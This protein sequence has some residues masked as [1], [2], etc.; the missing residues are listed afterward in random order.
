MFRKITLAAVLALSMIVATIGYISGA[1]SGMPI[2]IYVNERE[3]STDVSPFIENGTTFVPVRSICNAMRIDDIRW[4]GSDNTV[5]IKAENEIQFTVGE[6]YA[7]VNGKKHVL[8]APTVI[9]DGRTMIPVRLLAEAFGAYVEWDKTLY[10]VGISKD[11]LDVPSDCVESE[12]TKG[13]LLWLARIVHAESVGEPFDG[14]LAVANVVLN[15]VASNEY[16]NTIYGVIFDRKYGVQFQPVANGT[17]YNTPSKLSVM[18]S[19]R[20]LMGENNIGNCLYFL[21]ESIA[22][23]SWI[24][25]NREYYAKIHNHSFYV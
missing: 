13:D 25:E 24:T 8:S 3:I 16:P 12:Y 5:T 2:G 6:K 11:G 9:R 1:V 14:Q 17:V 10:C 7:F 19:K 21:N 23:S 15:R 18:A 4:D 20:A 22:T